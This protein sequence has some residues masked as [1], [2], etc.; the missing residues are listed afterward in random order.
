MKPV[1]GLCGF[2]GAGKTTLLSKLIPAL[3]NLGIRVSVIKHAHHNFDIDH[4]GKDSYKIRKSGA[5]QTLVA[6]NQRWALMTET[7]HVGNEPNLQYLLSQL[8]TSLIDIILVEGFKHAPI[9]KIE[10]Y[11]EALG[12]PLLAQEDSNVIAVASDTAL[13]ISR[14]HINL[15]DIEAIAQFIQT[16]F[17]LTS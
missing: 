16:R 3:N 5:K 6:S 12:K 13:P 15:N 1:L 7:P 9:P 2:S 14:T 17:K 11:R 10:I 8:D 4:P